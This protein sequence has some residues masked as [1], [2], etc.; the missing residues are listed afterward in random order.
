M[1]LYA[2]IDLHSNNSV[3]MVLDAQDRRVFA[4][5]LPN[6]VGAIVAALRSC[7]GE[8]RGVAVESTF[9]WYWLV[10]GLQDAGFTVHLVNTAAVKQYDGLKHGGDFSD[11]HHLA[12]L[13]RLGILPVGHIYPREQRAVRDLLRKRSQLVRQR[14]TQILCVHNLIARNL[15]TLTKGDAIKRMEPEDVESME[16]LEEQKQAMK[17]NLA[18]MD[19]LDEQVHKLERSV[20]AKFK[21]RE[22]FKALKTVSGIGDILALTIALETGDIGRF[23]GPGNFASYA[24]MVDSRRESNGKKKGQGNTK[25]G[26]KF[27]SWAFIEAAH[28]AVRFDA[29]IKRW[30][31][32]KCAS[33]LSVV[34]IKAVAH[35]LARACYHVIKDGQPFDVAKAFG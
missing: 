11:A 12:H 23:A 21:L 6:D 31:Q 7:A 32:K 30:Y 16:L 8:V 25:C 29:T 10:D 26:N 3:V 27:L 33:S 19:C 22:E 17:A 5:R 1:E 18:V 20:L 34:A 28:F 15:G 13:L 24:R 9:N 2:A 35:K 14:S 4:M